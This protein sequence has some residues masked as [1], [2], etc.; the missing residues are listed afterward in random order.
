[1]HESHRAEDITERAFIFACRI[2]R[3]CDGLLKQGGVAAVVGRQLCKAGTSLGANLE[4]A[5]GAQSKPDFIT[6]NC[7]ALKEGRESLY[8]LRLLVATMTP[9][10]ADAPVLRKEAN[11][12]VAIL[13]S[14]VKK[15]RSRTTTD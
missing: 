9:L 12:L 5:K 1:M 8:W 3:L 15:L 4:E 7:I 2:L 6:K 10:P 13:T 14:I 11:E